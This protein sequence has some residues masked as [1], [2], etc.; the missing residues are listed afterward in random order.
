MLFSLRLDETGTD[1]RSPITVVAGAVSTPDRWVRLE[2]Q[3]DNLLRRSNVSAFH[4]KEFSQRQDEFGGWSD[5]KAR[6][7]EGFAQKVISDNTLF[8]VSYGVTSDKHKE[9]KDRL[10]GMKGFAPDSD[11]GICLR[12]M[13]F[14]VCEQLTEIDPDCTLSV[15]VEDGP[16]AGAAHQLYLKLRKMTGGGSLRA[17]HA[18]RLVGF[19]SVPKGVRRSLEAAD[20]LA[21]IAHPRLSQEKRKKSGKPE[22]SLLLDDA[23]LEWFYGGIVKE[24]ERRREHASAKRSNRH[25][26]GEG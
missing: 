25:H 26:A 13:L 16:Y 22:L 17:K 6:R 15:M 23:K 1:G 20:F 9:V 14:Q 11:Y 2:T 12:A 24:K 19:S 21:G 7:F 10:K 3:W 8:R 4:Y 5:F 18:H